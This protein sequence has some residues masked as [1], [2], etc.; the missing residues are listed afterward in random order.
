MTEEQ[1]EREDRALPPPPAPPDE[2]ARACDELGVLPSLHLRSALHTSHLS[3]VGRSV[4]LLGLRA[5]FVALAVGF[6]TL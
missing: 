4:G 5:L 3:L 6:A 2:Y 1:L